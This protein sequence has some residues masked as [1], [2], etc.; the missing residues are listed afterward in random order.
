[1]T[2][3]TR[4]RIGL[5]A[6]LVMGAGGTAGADAQSLAAFP[7]DLPVWM[8]GNAAIDGRVLTE[9]M[10]IEFAMGGTDKSGPLETGERVEARVLQFRSL[11]AEERDGRAVWV[12]SFESR[13][14]DDPAV[15]VN[16]EIV[17]DRVTLAPLSSRIDQGGAVTTFEY[18]WTTFSVRSSQGGEPEVVDLK[19]LEAAAHE[20]WVAAIDW[21]AGQRVMI[22]TILAGGGGK[23]WAVP[24][25]TGA[26]D[27]D[28]G[29]GILRSAWTIEMD[30]WGMG[31]DQAVFTPGGGPNGSAGAGGKYWVLEEPVAGLPRVVRIQT[32]QDEN[33]DRVLQI[34][35]HDPTRP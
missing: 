16:G 21:S 13:R 15:L 11:R 35:G 29:D 8:V 1:M 25:V 22:P 26:E 31:R 9:Y 3:E 24:R 2:N 34:Q 14:P 30:W 17:L 7:T 19:V 10:E 18:D 28:L 27:I 6:L 23:W 33:V 32:E 12:R 20:T 5:M 4:T